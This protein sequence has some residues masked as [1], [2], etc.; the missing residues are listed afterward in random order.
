MRIGLDVMGGD[1]YP[2]AP[3]A[4]V[5]QALDALKS[6]EKV[7]LFGQQAVIETE[8]AKYSISASKI[9]ILHCEDVIEMDEHPAKAFT[10]KTKSSIATGYRMLKAQQI[11]AFISAGNTGAMLVGSVLG[12]GTIQGI[13]RPTIGAIYPNGNQPIL[14]LDVG[15][16][17]DAKPEYLAQWAI[18]GTIYMTEIFNMPKPRVGLLNIGEEK[19]KGNALTQNAYPLLEKETGINFIGNVEGR[20]F[21]KNKADIIVCDGFVGNIILK[22]A[23]SFYEVMKPKIADT[24]FVELYNFENYGGIPILGVQGVAIIGHGISGPTAY[25]N[26]ILRAKDIVQANLINKLTAAFLTQNAE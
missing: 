5:I 19:S 13:Q 26:M 8:L 22:F 14:I 1:Y 12:L 10:A 6:E 3:I 17:A 9:E 4:G 21:N 16:N 24:D 15:A 2:H 18:I 23:E 11:D 20:D 7:I 25:K